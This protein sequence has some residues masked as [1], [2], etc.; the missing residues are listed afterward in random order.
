MGSF[1]SNASKG[2]LNRFIRFM[3]GNIHVEKYSHGR[4][5]MGRDSIF[6]ILMD[7]S[8]KWER[9]RYR[10]PGSWGRVTDKSH[11]VCLRADFL[12]LSN[13]DKAGV[14]ALICLDPAHKD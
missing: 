5:G 14:V 8:S 12:F 13:N 9:T 3:T 6:V 11:L 7:S 4:P 1:S 10:E 2:P